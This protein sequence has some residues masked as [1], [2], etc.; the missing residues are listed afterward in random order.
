MAIEKRP[1]IL[2]RKKIPVSNV[3]RINDIVD[4]IDNLARQSKKL[5]SLAH[6]YESRYREETN[7]AQGDSKSRNR[8]KKIANDYIRKAN[9][10]DQQIAKL[11]QKLKK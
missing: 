1:N 8:N 3:Q 10:L 4:K 5:R 7:W 9:K 2:K 11:H 6:L